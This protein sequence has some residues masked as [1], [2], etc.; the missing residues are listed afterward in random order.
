MV[1]Q[2]RTRMTTA[3]FWQMMETTDERFELIDGEAIPIGT[4]IPAHQE[5][6]GDSYTVLKDISK[7]IGGKAYLSP[8]EVYLDEENIPQPDVMW[9]APDSRCKVTDSRLEGP[10]DLIVEV[11]S[12]STR[13]HDRV[14]KFRLYEKHGVREYW[15]ID[16]A[17]QYI[18]VWQHVEG[19]YVFFG[20]FKPD[21]TFNSPVLNGQ[22]IAVQVLFV[23]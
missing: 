14:T 18:E 16:P 7:V 9:L 19:K 22:T 8:L 12:P 1:E 23:T 11:F 10:P 13:Q 6:V 20:V 2:T 21:E 15:M 17:A 3:E 4:P 5:V